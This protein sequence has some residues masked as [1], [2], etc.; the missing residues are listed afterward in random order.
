MKCKQFI[1]IIFLFFIC[2]FAFSQEVKNALLIANGEYG[3]D[4]E[5]LTNPIPEARGLKIALESIGFNVT[6]I[7]NA[8]RE[9]MFDALRAFREKCEKTYILE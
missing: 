1:F 6:I 3:N 2:T 8:N 4:I 9:A 5:T 7:E